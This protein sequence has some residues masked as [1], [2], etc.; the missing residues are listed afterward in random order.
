KPWS[1][2]RLRDYIESCS[3]IVCTG[4]EHFTG[5]Y[6]RSNESSQITYYSDGSSLNNSDKC[7]SYLIESSEEEN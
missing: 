3:N 4:H 7:Y 5:S 6:T 1:S 2:K